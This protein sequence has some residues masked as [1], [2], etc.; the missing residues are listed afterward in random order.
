V[1]VEKWTPE[2][3]RNLTR[4]AL[5][6]AA[7]VVFARRGFEGAS[8]DEIAETAG[9]TRGAIYKNFGGKEELFFAVFDRRVEANL[10]AFADQ[11]D[12]VAVIGREPA[13]LAAAWQRVLARDIDTFALHLEFR[14]Y[15]L[16]NVDVR[17][18]YVELLRNERA[19][20]TAFLEEMA[21]SSGASF[22]LPVASI[23]AMMDAASEGFLAAAYF[24]P[25]TADLYESFLRLVIPVLVADDDEAPGP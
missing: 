23:A 4:R 9:F 11:F 24:D 22:R 16:R 3:R 13:E 20:V 2:R 17:D 21:A 14:L 5:V 8:L 12:G 18:R 10:A 19:A 15:A 1:A 25:T 6:D 7:A